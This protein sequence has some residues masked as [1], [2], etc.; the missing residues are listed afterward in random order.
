MGYDTNFSG[1]FKL[2]KPLT[3]CQIFYLNNFSS[4]RHM[5]RQNSLL[6]NDVILKILGLPFGNEGEFF[7][8]TKFK[9]NIPLWTPQTHRLFNTEFK[10]IVMALMCIQKYH[11]SNIDVNI[12]FMIIRYLS[13][14]P[15]TMN[16]DLDESLTYVVPIDNPNDRK[17]NIIDHNTPPFSQPG[18]WCQW[19]VSNDGT[20]IQWDQGEKFYEYIG[21]ITY[22]INNFLIPWGYKLSGTVNYQGEDICDCGSISIKNNTVTVLKIVGDFHK[23][24][25]NRKI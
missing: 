16:F 19:I 3:R 18:L 4:I 6:P 24:N 17:L 2:D 13:Q 11:M 25:W 5:K 22:I 15:Y 14:D 1:C 21:W 23:F 20:I 9:D 10:R 12:F 7:I 8:G